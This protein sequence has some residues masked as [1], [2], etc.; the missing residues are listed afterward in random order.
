MVR[1]ICALVS[2]L[3]AGSASAFAPSSFAL[4]Q[5]AARTPALQMS[6]DSGAKDPVKVGVIGCGRIGIVHLGA[7]NKAPGV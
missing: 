7:I 2:S 4:P 1:L 6:V 5:H 3:V